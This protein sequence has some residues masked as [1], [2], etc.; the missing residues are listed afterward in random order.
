MRISEM[1]GICEEKTVMVREG[2]FETVRLVGKDKYPEGKPAIAFVGSPLFVDGFLEEND[3]CVVCTEEVKDAIIDRYDG[4]IAVSGDPAKSFFEIHNYLAKANEVIRDN[5][6]DATVQVHST[7]II[8]DGNV[9]IGANTVIGA[10]AIIKS[11]TVIG[12][13]CTIREGVVIGT[14]GFYY[15]GTGDEKKLVVNAGGVRI[16][17]NVELHPQ[18]VVEKGVLYG[19]T[20]IGDNT[21]IDNLTLIGHDSHIGKNCIIAAGTTFAGGVT[22]RD[23]AFAGVGVT[24]APYV[25]IGE[26]AKLSSGAV[27]TKRVGAG[28]HVSG[29]FAI[30]HKK[31]VEHIKDISK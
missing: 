2:T 26:N 23:G 29:N 11:G 15:Y 12:R 19:N 9:V 30:E 22:F 27:A 25:T 18:T 10:R 28:E 6:I 13:D 3:E 21:K 17:N 16:G 8:E 4:G 7:A 5:V 24:V 14:P 31:Y 20:T 1:C